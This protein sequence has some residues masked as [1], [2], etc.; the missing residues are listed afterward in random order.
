MNSFAHSLKNWIRNS[1][2]LKIFFTGF[3][4]LVLLIPTLMIE[5]LVRE[6]KYT[7]RDAQREVSQKWGLEQ[8]I[9]GPILTVP[10]KE[11]YN[12][13]N[14]NTRLAHFLPDTLNIKGDMDSEIRSRGIFDVPLY[15]TN[16]NING[17]FSLPN[18][19]E[20]NVSSANI[21]WNQAYLSFG[22]TDMRGLKEQLAIDWSEQAL[23][24][25]PGLSEGTGLR[26]GLSV[27]IKNLNTRI[28]DYPFS[29]DL[30]LN[31]SQEIRF[32][33]LGRETNILLSS[34]WSSPSFDGAFL[35]T[36][37]E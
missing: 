35:P 13:T 31:G 36:E 19:S 4:V 15:T 34:D 28:P 8:S 16:L 6:R 30:T 22:I 33:P 14:F 11:Y 24:F 10:Y 1:L 5:G 3:L 18:F 21:L 12:R 23:Q 27:P 29:L 20:L 7:S 26:S 2:G 9:A 17:A 25:R 37:H 32:A